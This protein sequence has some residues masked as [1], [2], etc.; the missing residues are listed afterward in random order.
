MSTDFEVKCG[1]ADGETECETMSTDFL[2]TPVY[3]QLRE[4]VREKIE[5]GEYLPGTAIPTEN[6]LANMYNVNRLT[7]RSAIDALVIE[8]LLKRVQGKGVFV[9]G[10]KVE[11]DLEF[12]GGFSQTMRSRNK[13]P[14]IKVLKKDIRQAGK[15]YGDIF[16]I[17]ENAMIYDIR[18]L[19][20]ADDEPM[21]L[22]EIYV[23]ASLVPKIEGIDLSVF[24]MTEVYDFYNVQLCRAEQTLDIVTLN[25]NDARL[26][27]VDVKQAV[28]LF[29]YISYD[30][31]GRV[32]EFSHCYNRG[33]KCEFSVHFKKK[34]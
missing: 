7:V 1:A 16:G 5:D 8:G 25:Q 9:V 18:R 19:C 23:P 2:P 14:K 15:K 21:S 32:I 22:E 12:I 30:K 29:E 20:Y 6:A 31:N 11:R 33:D 13:R 4:I 3:L 34:S 10:N 17:S 26:L 27:G 28:F 24:S